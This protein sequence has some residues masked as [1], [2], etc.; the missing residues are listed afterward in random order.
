MKTA[1]DER[2]VYMSARAAYY[3]YH[4]EER[5]KKRLKSFDRETNW[6]RIAPLD[7]AWGWVTV[8]GKLVVNRIQQLKATNHVR[9]RLGVDLPPPKRTRVKKTAQPAVVQAAA[10]E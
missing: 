2:S 1:L 6:S 8:E 10:A 7:D 3:T 4:G 9:A 5:R